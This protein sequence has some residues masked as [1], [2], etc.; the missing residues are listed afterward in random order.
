MDFRDVVG[1]V[2][3]G[4]G[5]DVYWERLN[6]FETAPRSRLMRTTV[7]PDGTS[8]LSRVLIAEL[9][10]YEW[11][12]RVDGEGSNVQAIWKNPDVIVASPVVNGALKYPEGKYVSFGDYADLICHASE[13]AVVYTVAGTQR[14][15]FLDADSNVIG[16]VTLPDGFHP[17]SVSFSEQ[18]LFFVRH[19]LKQLRAALVRRD[20]SVLYDIAIADADPAAFEAGPVAIAEN[21][22][23]HVVAFVDYAP[24]PVEVHAV[25]ISG[26]GTM[27]ERVRLLQAAPSIFD[28]PSNV[29]S[30]SL[31]W[32]GTIYALGYVSGG[33]FLRRYDSAFHPL[34]A[35]PQR[36]SDGA[37][38]S[39]HAG[40]EKFVIAWSAAK[41]Y[42]T[43]L[44]PNGQ[45]TPKLELDPMPRR[46]AVR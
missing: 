6:E 26:D 23:Q 9:D 19:Q 7:S 18:G 3:H 24:E 10:E 38:A 34:D 42:L 1:I 28:H 29:F 11:G 36:A 44:S 2:P 45:M 12:S 30:L 35:E 22:N 16:S 31:A 39:V 14:A 40:G 17:L 41:P 46:R 43:I 4:A 13:C 25:T 15:T 27:S 37:A 8:R 21:G 33:S 20:G 32:N 5:I